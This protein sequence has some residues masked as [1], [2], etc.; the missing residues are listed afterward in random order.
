LLL[1]LPGSLTEIF[2]D[3]DV[4]LRV[5]RAAFLASGSAF[6]YRSALAA[7]VDGR[8][9]GMMVRFPGRRWKRLRLQTGLAMLRAA[10]PP[11]A[12]SLVW[13]GTRKD[14]RMAPVPTDVLF[15]MAVAVAPGH[16]GRGVGTAFLRRAA[17]EAVRLG[18]RAIALDVAGSNP[19]AVRLYQR[20]GYEACAGRGSESIRM[21]RPVLGR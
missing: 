1:E 13:R 18:L 3:R 4:A 19:G 15:L 20:E 21:E 2:P 17:E 8:V 7:V 6:G 16:R 9:V 5:A 12:L 10:G 11:H 14:R